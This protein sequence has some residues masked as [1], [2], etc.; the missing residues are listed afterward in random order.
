MAASTRRQKMEE[1]LKARLETLKNDF[2]AGNK[3]LSN[4]QGQVNSLTTTLIRIQGAI[5]VLEESLKE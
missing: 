4:L 5:Q 1:K 3:Q 2:E